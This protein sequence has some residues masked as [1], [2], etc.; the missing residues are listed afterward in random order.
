[1]VVGLR[2]GAGT[3]SMHTYCLY[4]DSD[5]YGDDDGDADNDD[6][7]DADSDDEIVKMIVMIH[8]YK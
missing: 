3:E 1:V 4:H 7:S 2:L 6:D 8:K 5:D